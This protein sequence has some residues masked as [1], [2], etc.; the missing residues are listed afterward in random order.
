MASVTLE[1]NLGSIECLVFPKMYKN[2]GNMDRGVSPY[3]RWKNIN[4]RW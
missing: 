4:K 1:N 3:D 2:S